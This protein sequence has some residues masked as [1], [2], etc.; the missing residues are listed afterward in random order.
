MY[1]LIRPVLFRLDA[2]RAHDLTLLALRVLG[3]S[4]PLLRL[5]NLLYALDDPRLSVN[6]FGL[7]FRN[8]VGLAAG[9]DKNA[10][11]LRGLSA[12]GFGHVE[13]GTVTLQPQVG[14]PRPRIHRVPAAHAL[15][16]SM[17]FPN[18]GVDRLL[19][20]VPPLPNRRLPASIRLGINIGKG[21]DTPLERSNQDYC[22]L[23]QRVYRSADY[24]TVNISS[25]NTL[26][27][28]Q[29]Q[30]RAAIESL[31]QA[32]VRVR[33][34]FTRRVP[35]LVKIAPDL[36]AGELDD[37]LA[38]V[39]NSAVDGVIATNTT[40]ARDGV[41]ANL[42]GLKGGLSGEPLRERS[43]EVVRYLSR[44]TGGHLP[45]V[46]VGGIASG[47]DALAMLRAG[48]HLVQVYTGLVYAGPGLA[49]QIN[50][51]LLAACERHKITNIQEL[52]AV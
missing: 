35:V 50:R 28:R 23:L 3:H 43:L 10:L 31:L 5:F 14:N 27:L 46:G 25:P 51:A 9:Y 47:E 42:A 8:P 41:P 38:A 4:G 24:V 15:I 49:H 44:Q 29:L 13:V 18:A 40:I 12:L 48:A 39:S 32:I 1:R 33:S 36:S 11:A 6:A 19:A 2:E 37:V 30:A 52:V 16:N 22:T 34:S 20:Q 26:G 7:T 21:K 17:G 45:I